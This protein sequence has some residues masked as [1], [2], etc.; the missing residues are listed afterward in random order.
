MQ[1]YLMAQNLWRCTKEGVTAPDIG[2]STEEIEITDSKGKARI[3]EITKVTNEEEVTKWYENAE[4]ALGSIHLRL[5]ENIGLQYSEVKSPAKL[6]KALLTAYGNPGISCAFA[7]F[8]GAMDAVIPNGSD[9]G[10]ALAKIQAHFTKCQGHHPLVEDE[11]IKWAREAVAEARGVSLRQS[12]PM[13]RVR[14]GSLSKEE[15]LCGEVQLQDPKLT[16][17]T[18]RHKR[19]GFPER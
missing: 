3:Q 13:E 4:K 11:T 8:K 9:S 6:W 18:L 2:T 12:L 17:S 19:M 14:E 10:P 16:A 5:A 15:S 7:E 1:S